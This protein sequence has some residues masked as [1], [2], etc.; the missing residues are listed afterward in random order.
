MMTRMRAR[1]GRRPRGRARRFAFV[2]AMLAGS[3]VWASG[4]NVQTADVVIDDDLFQPRD[5]TVA[6]GTTVN[7]RQQGANPHTVTADDGS[8]DSNI[9]NTGATF[10]QTFSQAGTVRYHCSIHGAPGGV[11]MSGTITVTA[12]S[13]AP[14]PQDTQAPDTSIDS[15]PS[16][17]V[18]ADSAT[19][20]FS[21]SEAGST[22]ACS[23][24]AGPFESC[25]APTTYTGLAP[26]DHAFAVRATDAVGNTDPSPATRTW[27]V[28][29]PPPSPQPTRTADTTPPDTRIDAGPGGD[30]PTFSFSSS[31]AGSSFECSLDG[32]PFEAC[33]S[34]KGY[35]GLAPGLH[36]F[37]V[38]ARD[39]ARNLDATPAS[40]SFTVAAPSSPEPSPSP[41]QTATPTPTPPVSTPAEREP[42]GEREL[43]LAVLG[44]SLLALLLAGL[45]LAWWWTRRGARPGPGTTVTGTPGGDH[46]PVP[47]PAPRGDRCVLAHEWKLEFMVLNWAHPRGT[48]RIPACDPVPMAAGAVDSHLLELSC[49]CEHGGEQPFSTAP[50][51]R[52]IRMLARVRYEWSVAGEGGFVAINDADP[53]KTDHGEQ[54]LYLPPHLDLNEQKTATITVRAE[55]DDPTKHPAAHEGR[56]VEAKVT[57]KRVSPTMVEV[58]VEA[59]AASHV[60][61]PAL[62]EPTEG[63]CECRPDHEWK[64]ASGIEASI[65]AVPAN[66]FV[67][68]N[69]H[70]R[71]EA[72]G[73]DVDELVL[74]CL[75]EVCEPCEEK[76][77]VNDLLAYTWTASAGR[78]PAGN[79]G[80]CVAW[81]APAQPG[82]VEITVT[83]S[84]VG[85]QADD[86]D[87]TVTTKVDV[88]DLGIDLVKVPAAWL[89]DARVGKVR[90]VARI[91]RCQGGSWVYPGRRKVVT[92]RLREVSAERGVCLN[93]PLPAAANRN[94]DLFLDE[95][96][97]AADFILRDDGT[98]AGDPACITEILAAGD[99]PAHA[100]HYQAA[101]TKRCVREAQAVV[102]C[103]DYG[104]FGYLEA[105]AVHCKAIPP[106]DAPDAAPAA[107]CETAFS[108]RVRIPRDDNGND[109]ADSAP[110]DA[111]G[112]AAT[113]DGDAAPAGDGTNGDG[114][115]NYEEYRGFVVGG[116]AV[117][118][119]HVPTDVARKDVFVYD[120]DNLGTGDF[121]QS[122]LTIH[123]LRDPDLYNGNANRVI[124][125]NRGHA[126]G[127]EQHGLH[128]R[129][130]NGLGAGIGGA[131]TGAGAAPWTPRHVEVVEINLAELDARIANGLGNHHGR[132]RAHEL[133][134]ATH[135]LHHGDGG[136]HA[137]PPGPG[138]AANTEREGRTH[139]GDVNCV[140]RY[141][142]RSGWCHAHGGNAHH[143]H[144]YGA[145]VVGNTYCNAVNGTGDNNAG[146]GHRNDASR[147]NCRGQFR[148]KDW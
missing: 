44:A 98:R 48:F 79:R 14:S 56:S 120:E 51:T 122:G 26:G 66:P 76:L 108:N 125:F 140:M 2:L 20:T 50:C 104:A 84:D 146:A 77:A 30:P 75:S 107:N 109:I 126:T 94:P 78:F 53:A 31:E 43:P 95:D 70:V 7:W 103:E 72:A 134:H 114:L 92:F 121:A 110:Q 99:N 32:G 27:S 58:M 11:G 21:S 55:H 136:D 129:R 22:F 81:L 118:K 88:C 46:P 119:R 12:P 97:M 65:A 63:D 47:V 132:V 54:V 19:F 38:R 40:L 89:P 100:H 117:A 148:V 128:L 131:T 86:E 34:P 74:R 83:V 85:G 82:K 36:A 16:G 93:Y 52:T 25:T 49:H 127:G 87:P 33:T 62:P 8:F 91:Y 60:T 35:T 80:R 37:A 64:K 15:G 130:N 9:L 13:P 18:A 115:T 29:T 4:A 113:T 116:G 1:S 5:L 144:A 57:C 67:A 124:N 3:A 41:T 59:P 17:P 111:A 112:A 69:D 141:V 71:L 138:G 45:F 61:T 142:G 106:R 139:S 28:S 23:L 90:P 42:A 24:D 145:M 147:G 39:Q 137:C 123:I 10:S 6:A 68:V 102:R 73:T 105:R 101:H 96:D 143:R 135:V 133:G